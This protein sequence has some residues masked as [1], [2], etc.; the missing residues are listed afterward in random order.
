MHIEKALLHTLL[1][2]V[3]N[4][5]KN[6]QCILN[7]ISLDDDNFDKEDP[8]TIIHIRSLA[9]RNRF[10]QCKACKKDISK[11]LMLVEWHPTRWWDWCLSED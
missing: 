7:D 8:E 3:F 5:L 2:L 9:W 1:L 11:E 10:K 6:L 4:I